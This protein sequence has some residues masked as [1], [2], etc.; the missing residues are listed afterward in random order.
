MQKVF[1][2]VKIVLSKL[3]KKN[4]GFC[5]GILKIPKTGHVRSKVDSIELQ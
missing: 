1:V 3:I 5:P 2:F 4:G